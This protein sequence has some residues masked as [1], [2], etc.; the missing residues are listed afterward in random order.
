MTERPLFVLGLDLDGTCADFYARMREIASEWTGQP[1]ES[2]PVEPQWGL[3]NWGIGMDNYTRLHR[4][5][6]TQRGLFETM[7]PI[8]DAPQAIRR[9]GTEGIRIRIITHRLFIR[10]FHEVAV[11][12]TV[13]WL[14][15]W[16]IPYWDLCFMRDKGEV[17]ADLY[18]ED[19]PENILALRARNKE[20]IILSNPT[21]VGLADDPGGRADGWLA[22][23]KM[24]RRRYYDWLDEHGLAR[25]PGVG[26]EPNWATDSPQP[27]V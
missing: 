2:L 22:A 21:N 9:L 5:A 7:K 13:R 14:D 4:F 6:V 27:T 10:Y 25:P 23:E 1:L 24:I 16:S 15:Y 11:Q 12:Q 3:G 19:S 20:V 17:G 26:R 18:V 8:A